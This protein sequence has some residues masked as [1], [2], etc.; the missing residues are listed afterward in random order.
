MMLE[1][2]LKIIVGRRKDGKVDYETGGEFT[3][4][5]GYVDKDQIINAHTLAIQELNAKIEAHIA[6]C[7]CNVIPTQPQAAPTQGGNLTAKIL[8]RAPDIANGKTD[9]LQVEYANL[10]DAAAN[11]TASLSGRTLGTRAIAPRKIATSN[12]TTTVKGGYG[13]KKLI[14]THDETKSILLDIQL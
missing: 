10:T 4:A 3:T 8:A 12:Y 11:V 13:G 5:E 7:W 2:I 9:T 1:R 14:I 6:Q